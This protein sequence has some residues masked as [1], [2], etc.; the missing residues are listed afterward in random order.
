MTTKSE[1]RDALISATEDFR[2]A[3]EVL[4]QSNDPKDRKHAE[5]TLRRAGWKKDG[6]GAFKPPLPDPDLDH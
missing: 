1:R 2:E 6:N 3:L 5:N 4:Q